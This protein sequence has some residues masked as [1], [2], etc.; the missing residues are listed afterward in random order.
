MPN[1]G[2]SRVVSPREAVSQGKLALTF[3][4]AGI[5]SQKAGLGLG[6][7]LPH[8]S[9]HI[10]SS[11]PI[12]SSIH[13]H[14]LYTHTTYTHVL[15][16]VNPHVSVLPEP[17]RLFWD[18][19]SV[20]KYLINISCG[21]VFFLSVTSCSCLSIC[22]NRACSSY[23]SSDKTR[24]LTSS[25]KLLK[26]WGHNAFDITLKLMSEMKLWLCLETEY[27]FAKYCAVYAVYY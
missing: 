7:I 4:P 25:C 24:L 10:P 17:L 13:T 22:L 27:L 12:Q 8:V 1:K 6:L 2:L 20:S 19:M 3:L 9:K 18:D 26:A 14:K 15:A 23:C 21:C 5:F 16:Y 11:H